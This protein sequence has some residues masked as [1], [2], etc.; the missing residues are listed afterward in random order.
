ML[1]QS[2]RLLGLAGFL[3]T[4]LVVTAGLAVS[5]F[6][7]FTGRPRLLVATSVVVTSWLACYAMALVLGPVLTA[8]RTLARGEELHFCGLD[9][10]LHVSVV[11]VTR[12]HDLVVTIRFRSDARAA[13]EFPSHLTMRVVDAAGEEY[14]A[15]TPRDWPP[16]PA[17]ESYEREIRFALPPGA[18]PDRLIATR[19]D[20]EDYLVP[21]PEN[22][23]VQQRRALRLDV[24]RRVA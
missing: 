2:L 21:G 18:A 7:A 5:V 6:S 16:L 22:A 11:R 1:E 24:P 14:Q 4:A 8:R 10:H 23:L 19:G 15:A 3:L 12:D 9:C 13:P 20:W 17:G